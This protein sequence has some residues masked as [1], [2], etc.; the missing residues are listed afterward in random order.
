M[1]ETSSYPFVV[2]FSGIQDY[3]LCPRLWYIKHRLGYEPV[4]AGNSPSA[5]GTAFHNALAA[6]RTENLDTA[7]RLWDTESAGFTWEQRVIG[8]TLL[9]AYAARYNHDAE[10]RVHGVPVI[11]AEV[12][13]PLLDPYG[14]DDGLILQGHMDAVAY[15]ANGSTYIIED[16]TTGSDITA[17]SYWTRAERG[18]QAATYLLLC[19]T[20]GRPAAGVIWDAIRVP[21]LERRM[22]T[23]IDKRE[24]YVRDCKYG[25]AGEPKPGTR[26]TDET[27]EEFQARIVEMITTRPD[28]FFVRQRITKTESELYDHRIDLWG[29]ATLVRKSAATNVGPAIPRNPDAC[30]KF[31]AHPCAYVPVCWQ[32][33]SLDNMKLYRIR[34]K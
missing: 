25:K 14:T 16:K 15:D 21:R 22:A 13:I 31:P 23:D 28:D 29:W 11:E 7:V 27:P 20:A 10:F 18:G 30:N 34:S 6:L 12:E 2:R 32:G 5:F 19:S 24:F 4:Q 8:H 9:I 1:S 33:A 17:E 3:R 26:L